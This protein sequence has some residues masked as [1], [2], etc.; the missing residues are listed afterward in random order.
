[1]R[2]SAMLMLQQHEMH[3]TILIRPLNRPAPTA[4]FRSLHNQRA[5]Q[6][7]KYQDVAE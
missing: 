4:R 3:F 6:R 1:M 5:D 2:I 7:A